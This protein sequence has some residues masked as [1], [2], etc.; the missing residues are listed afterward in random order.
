M[1]TTCVFHNM[2]S[3]YEKVYLASLI[4]LSFHVFDFWSLFN[5]VTVYDQLDKWR[6]E[7]MMKC[8]SSNQLVP[9]YIL[10]G[11]VT[12]AILIMSCFIRQL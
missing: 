1:A 10:G 12:P 7:K 6:Q 9:F 5:N 11:S 2:V 4:S 8:Q 3:V